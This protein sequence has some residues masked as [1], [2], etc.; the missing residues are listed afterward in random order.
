MY[1]N[2]V[3]RSPTPSV[4]A[5]VEG[6]EVAH[7]LEVDLD[8]NAS[9][10]GGDG[11]RGRV[12]AQGS[13]PITAPP[14]A[15]GELLLRH[16]VRAQVDRAAVAVDQHGE[17]LLEPRQE[18]RDPDHAGDTE[19]AREDRAMRE[20][21]A[22][23]RHDR[24][25]ALALDVGHDLRGQLGRG[26]DDALLGRR[27]RLL[28]QLQELVEDGEPG[29]RHVR[30]V[31]AHAVALE[32]RHLRAQ[33]F[34]ERLDAGFDVLAAFANA[35]FE[36][37]PSHGILKDHP[38]DGEDAGVL[39]ARMLAGD[40]AA[41]LELLG[42]A[43]HRAVEA[44]QLAVDLLGADGPLGDD[45]RSRAHDVH[46][47]ER[48]PRG[49]GDALDA[50]H[51]P[52]SVSGWACAIRRVL[53]RALDSSLAG[54]R[55]AE[56]GPDDRSEAPRWQGRREEIQGNSRAEQQDTMGNDVNRKPRARAK[57]FGH[58]KGQAALAWTMIFGG[59]ATCALAVATRLVPDAHPVLERGAYLL[60]RAGLETSVLVLAG[61]GSGIAGLVLRAVSRFGRL[62]DG[63]R[64]AANAIDELSRTASGHARAVDSVRD[65]IGAL[66]GELARTQH[67]VD[68]HVQWSHTQ[69][70]E[71]PVFRLAA[72]LDQLWARVDQSVMAARD[73]LIHEVRN[74]T[75]ALRKVD[76]DALQQTAER[77]ERGLVCVTQSIDALS[78]GVQGALVAAERAAEAAGEATAEARRAADQGV[79]LPAAADE[80]TRA[81][82]EPYVHDAIAE[83][84][85]SS[86]MSF[87]DEPTAEAPFEPAA[88]EE[89][90]EH[91]ETIDT[92]FSVE[93]EAPAF[94]L[95]A[96]HEVAPEAGDDAEVESLPEAVELAEPSALD[97]A[98]P[99]FDG[100]PMD[101]FAPVPEEPAV[102]PL[103]ET[104]GDS[105][106]T[107]GR[108]A[109]EAWDFEPQ[110]P[111]PA[112]PSEE[113]APPALEAPAPDPEAPR[114]LHLQTQSDQDSEPLSIEVQLDSAFEDKM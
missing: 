78:N 109:P 92:E 3:R 59:A 85:P 57:G 87:D 75:V 12:L 56:P 112:L 34:D 99:V 62:L 35:L 61:V 94:E 89:Q 79:H 18:V 60:G 14:T 86:T 38:V 114:V 82:V 102:D 4:C 100:P 58:A 15:G 64:E 91:P 70:Q 5:G 42:H 73:E 93:S 45:V 27:H 28:I 66:C 96:P 21:A 68:E 6:I 8:R 49:D 108:P 37:L 80:P 30:R 63:D 77:V 103:A 83:A 67:V 54:S 17:V 52:S 33:S 7:A 36:L 46:R 48:E 101:T 110:E 16:L 71:N 1:R 25:H 106:D 107:T 55:G 47:A 65:E 23:F 90:P 76:D 97:V 95:E 72:S 20:A 29:L 53:G 13:L 40:L 31:G 51:R 111:A 88:L 81:D 10:V 98:G 74:A 26:E 11:G 105:F 44:R 41:A 84:E 43:L 50:D 104:L 113:V 2:S 69:A 39:L 19:R 22:R 9:T 24:E 32:P